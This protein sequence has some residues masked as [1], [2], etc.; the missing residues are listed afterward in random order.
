MGSV[1]PRALLSTDTKSMAIPPIDT[2]KQIE[3]FMDGI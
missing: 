1:N 3:G 2:S